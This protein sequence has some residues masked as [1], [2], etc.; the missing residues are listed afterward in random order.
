MRHFV[1][2][3]YMFLALSIPTAFAKKHIVT[4]K[5]NHQDIT[6][7]NEGENAEKKSAAVAGAVIAGGELALKILTKILDEI[8]KID[9]K[10]AIG[11]DNESGL[12]WTALNTYYKSGASDV[13]LPYEVEN[14]KALLYTARKSKGPVARGAVGVLAYKMSSGNTLAVMFSVPFDY[15]LYTNW[16]NVKI[17]DGEKKA[18]EKMYNELY[19]NNNP[20]K[21]SI[22]EKRDLG[23][24]GL[25]L[26][27]FMTSNGDAKLVIHIEKS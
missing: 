9:R 4:K 16:W 11:V 14:S 22:W 21:P 10:I 26:R 24:D 6:N 18:D 2:F 12:K 3:L 5:G 13:T 19:N 8:G 1:V 7:D 27:G 25:K 20:I 17:Y 15:N 23:Q